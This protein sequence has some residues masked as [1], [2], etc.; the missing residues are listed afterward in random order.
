MGNQ[1]YWPNQEIHF[2]EAEEVNGGC[3]LVAWGKVA[4]PIDPGGTWDPQ[5]TYIRCDGY[6]WAKQRKTVLERSW[7]S[8]YKLCLPC[9]CYTSWERLKHHVLVRPLAAWLLFVGS[10]TCTCNGHLLWTLFWAR[11]INAGR[12]SRIRQRPHHQVAREML[13]RYVS[14]G[15]KLVGVCSVKIMFADELVHEIY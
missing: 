14:S 11:H 5:F 9:Q 12:R 6:G 4:R 7:T 2:M 8:Q 10:C 1:G 13:K 3:C 15:G